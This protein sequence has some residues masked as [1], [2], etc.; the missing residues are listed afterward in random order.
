VVTVSENMHLNKL[1]QHTFSSKYSSFP[2]VDSQGLL[3]GI[4]TFQDFKEVVFEEGLGDLVV[5]K[6]IANP[7]VI[8][9]TRNENLDEALEKIGMKN[10][11]QLPVVDENNPRKIVGILSRRDIFSAYNK[12]LFNKSLAKGISTDPADNENRKA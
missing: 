11:E 10:I 9:I 3:C 4:I 7:N 2:V 6:D 5:V 8:T 1:L 12:A